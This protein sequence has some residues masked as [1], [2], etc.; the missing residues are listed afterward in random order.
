MRAS[1]SSVSREVIDTVPVPGSGGLTC[2]ADEA[3]SRTSRIGRPCPAYA[4]STVANG[5][6]GPGWREGRVRGSS[7]SARSN[8]PSTSPG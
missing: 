3:L 2:S 6:P 1:T 8:S 7:L 4:S 5:G